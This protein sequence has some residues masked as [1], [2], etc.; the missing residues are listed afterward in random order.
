MRIA[1]VL[2]MVMALFAAGTA[3][4]ATPG[5]L[6]TP[7]QTTALINRFVT[8]FNA[9][10]RYGLNNIIWGGKLYFKWYTVLA[11]PGFRSQPEAS[12]RDTLMDYFAARHAAGERLTLTNVKINWRDIG[13]RNFE[14][15][16]VRSANDLPGGQVPYNGK[17]SS[18]CMNGRLTMWLMNATP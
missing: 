6:R 2:V 14:F 1:L 10:D 17:G 8:A 11:E 9:G 4:P 18:S 5:E 7:T 3:K 12:R 16:L 15:H 13:N